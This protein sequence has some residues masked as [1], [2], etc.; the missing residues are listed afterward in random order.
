MVATW[1]ASY[2]KAFGMCVN[3]TQLN[4]ALSQKRAGEGVL[5]VHVTVSQ[6][7]QTP[8]NTPKHA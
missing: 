6:Q 8:L 2:E 7:A 3:F 4:P 5:R 1:R